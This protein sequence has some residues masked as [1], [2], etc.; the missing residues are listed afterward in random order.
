[1]CGW[2]TAFGNVKILFLVWWL[3]G[4]VDAKT[5][6]CKAMDVKPA[7]LKP[8]DMEGPQYLLEKNIYI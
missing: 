2:E 4:S 3:V 5:H 6:G 7:D 1:M 8:W